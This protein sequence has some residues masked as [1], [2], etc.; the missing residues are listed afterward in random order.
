MVELMTPRLRLRRWRDDDVAA[1]SVI[2]ADPE[3]MRWIGDGSVRDRAATGA[4]IAA[5]EQ[6]WRACG[7]GRFAVEIRATG[8]LAGLTGMAI[9]A[10]VPAVMPAVEIG[11][12]FGRGYWGRGL[13]TEAATAALRF[14]FTDGGLD[15][16][17]GIHVVG[18]DASARVMLKLGMRFDRETTEVVYGRRMHVYAISREDL[19]A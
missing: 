5:S 13:A 1:M 7:F 8:E 18:N 2:N 16:V 3:V 15:R 10:D 14:A 4:E 17:V 6:L 11:W 19:A 12:R 9:P